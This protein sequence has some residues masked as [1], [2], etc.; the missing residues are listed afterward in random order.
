MLGQKNLSILLIL[1]IFCN[2]CKVTISLQGGLQRYFKPPNQL[3]APRKCSLQ[4]QF[5]KIKTGWKDD[6]EFPSINQ[7][8]HV[9][10]ASWLQTFDAKNLRHVFVASPERSPRIQRDLS[11]TSAEPEQTMETN[12]EPVPHWP[13]AFQIW[14]K[15][16]DLH[17]YLFAV[18]Y[19][20]IAATSG[21]ALASDILTNHGIKGL[22]LTL[23][24]TLMFLGS[25]RAII[26]FVDPYSS[27]GILDLLSTYI[28]WSLGFPCILTALSLLLLVFVEVTRMNLAPPRFQKL[29]TALGMMV[30]NILMVLATDLVFLLTQKGFVLLVICHVYF[31]LIGLILTAGFLRIGFRISNNAAADIYGDTGLTRLRVLAFISAALNLLFLGIQVYSVIRFGVEENPRA[32]PWYAEQTLLR[33]L[34][35]SMCVV[36]FSIVF[37]NRVSSTAAWWRNFLPNRFRNAVSPFAP[38]VQKNTGAHTLTWN[39]VTKA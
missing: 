12:P 3:M 10:A 22:K 1:F 39:N 18:L 5:F 13:T 17:I 24:L 30:I 38:V 36:M 2:E 21:I 33:V 16:W 9:G 15:A 31:L 34:E 35:V 7:Q 20:I 37:N 23:Y 6:Y 29:S 25:S 28:T 11:A 32:W 27:R 19:T 14:G 4:K 8:D 26:L